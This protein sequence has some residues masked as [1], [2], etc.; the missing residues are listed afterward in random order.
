MAEVDERT[1]ARLARK[2]RRQERRRRQ[3]LD[4]ARDLVVEGG[5]AALTMAAL[6]ERADTSASTL[7]YYLPGRDAVVDALAADLVDLETERLM[8]ALENS[9]GGVESLCAVMDARVRMYVDEPTRF[10]VLYLHLV[11]TS[12]SPDTLRE[13]IYP[14]SA[15]TMGELERRLR[16]DKEAGL[17]HPDLKPREFANVGF[18][19]TQ[20]ILATSLGM[21]ASGGAMRFPVDVLLE[22]AKAMVRRAARVELPMAA[23]PS[24]AAGGAETNEEVK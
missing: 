6:A 2:K 23:Q 21:Q 22:E 11:G 14:A 8:E 7:Y 4:A 5:M 9:E 16:A 15:K 1:A 10:G 18:F 19:A 24:H 20:G 13:R 12:I 17:V 3:L